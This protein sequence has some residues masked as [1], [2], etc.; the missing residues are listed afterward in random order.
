MSDETRDEN[1]GDGFRIGGA[2]PDPGADPEVEDV[3]P[4]RSV[5]E[6]GEEL[7]SEGDDLLP[8]WSEPPTGAAPQVAPEGSAQTPAEPMLMEAGADEMEVWSDLPPSPQWSES[9]G[10][11]PLVGTQDPN[12]QAMAGDDF[13]VY[14]EGAAG[15]GYG[16]PAGAVAAP[17]GDER[18]MPMAVVVGVVLAAAILLAM[19][20]GPAVTLI[21]VTVA[22]GLAAIEWLNAV[23]LA[24][25]QPAVL[26]GLAGVVAMPLAVY[27]RGEAA[28][29]VVCVL[30][31]VF[32]ALWYLT[33]IGVEGP[34][35]GLGATVFGVV[36]I[37]VLGSH[38]ALMLTLGDHGT[39]LL[40]TAIV[41]T[42]GY[43]IG[44]LFVGRAAGRTPLSSA[45]PAKTLE[46]LLGGCVVAV[47]A[48]VIMGILAAPAPVADGPGDLWTS[49]IMAIAIAIAA[50]IGDLAE[51]LLK[52]D[53][54]IKNMGALLPGHGGV[55]D[56]IDGLLFVLPVTYY[57]ALIADII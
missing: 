22:L 12:E 42:A 18:D 55:L 17:G 6:A 3:A 34:L 45:S 40:T 41:V 54:G 47:G 11:V 43:D 37:G 28:I 51:S 15:A 50:P 13:F 20:A 56:R 38:A 25:Y 1:A 44:G 7:F 9:E 26:L 2:Q 4:G 36:Y 48:G 31:V 39:G 10:S 21:V 14:D 53:L 33:G 32:G 19:T 52:R 24:G 30:T 46:G 27:W 49:I 23:R 8:H 35:R 5:F 16:M 29:P 57:V